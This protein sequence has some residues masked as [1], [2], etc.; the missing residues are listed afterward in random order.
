MS[1]SLLINTLEFAEQSLEIHDKILGSSLPRLRDVLFSGEGEIE[2]WLKGRRVSRDK[3]A[4]QLKVHGGLGLQCQRCLG[5]LVFPVE[6]DRHFEL[7]ADESTLPDSDLDDDEV[8]YLVHDPKLDVIGLVE[9]EILLA[10]PMAV[11]HESDCT[12]GADASGER[13]LNPFHVLEKL[14]KQH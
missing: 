7:I 6:I 8:D 1:T 13:K 14:K 12:L 10:L 2:Y 4:L 11:R 9:E 3:L 5:G